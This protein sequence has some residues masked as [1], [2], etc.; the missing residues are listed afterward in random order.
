[1]CNDECTLKSTE[2]ITVVAA[3]DQMTRRGR[4]PT[5]NRDEVVA[6]S[7]RLIERVGVRRFTMRGLAEELNTAKMTPYYHIGSKEKL[8]E[9]A[10]DAMFDQLVLPTPD[11]ARWEDQL[12]GANVAFRELLRRYRGMAAYMTADASSREVP[13]ARQFTLWYMDL[14]RVAG[15][16]PDIAA[17]ALPALRGLVVAD[18]DETYKPGRAKARGKRAQEMPTRDAD[19]WAATFWQQLEGEPETWFECGLDH[20]ILGLH[21]QLEAHAPAK[22]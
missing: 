8:L 3:N 14:M 4:P 13:G 15:F 20:V 12:R 17:G 19:P 21:R 16:E 5:V 11:A 9:L 10:A 22:R 6:A 1:V 18:L 7:L 2:R